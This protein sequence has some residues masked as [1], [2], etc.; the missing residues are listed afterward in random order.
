[1][2]ELLE[3][4]DEN[5]DRLHFCCQRVKTSLVGGGLTLDSGFNKSPQVILFQTVILKV[6][7]RNGRISITWELRN[8]NS[9][10]PP[11]LTK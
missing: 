6:W 8:A 10:A 2:S 3:A 5:T 9:Q 11:P 1:M 4:L 7:P